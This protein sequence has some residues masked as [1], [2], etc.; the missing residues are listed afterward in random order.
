MLIEREVMIRET[1]NAGSLMGTQSLRK[2]E[3]GLRVVCPVC[4]TD[5]RPIPEGVR[6]GCHIHGLVCPSNPQHYMLY[7]EDESAM[8]GMRI[9]MK[10]LT[11][12]RKHNVS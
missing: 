12:K 1:V 4:S 5:L 3:A 11:A 6:P 8:K 9:F 7:A 10:D 2:Y